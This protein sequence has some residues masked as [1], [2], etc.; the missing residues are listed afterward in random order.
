[1]LQNNCLKIAKL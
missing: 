1:M